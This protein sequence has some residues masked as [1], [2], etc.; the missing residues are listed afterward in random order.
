MTSEVIDPRPA[1]S[2]HRF[3]T[4]YAIAQ[5]REVDLNAE[6]AEYLRRIDD[7]LAP[8]G[9]KFLVHGTTPEVV[10]GDF[11]GAVVIIEFPGL[12]QAHA[13]YRSAGYQ[14]ILE[15]R[16]RNSDGGA[17]IVDGVANGYRAATYLE[18]VAG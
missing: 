16:T 5:L 1:G 11:P 3:M 14:E 6:V 13:W 17:V 15:F 2:H 9:G 4:A 8:F 7:T 10:D 18:K 12:E